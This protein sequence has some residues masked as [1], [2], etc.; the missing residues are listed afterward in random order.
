MPYDANQPIRIHD[1]P[2]P[3]SW[4]RR[5]RWFPHMDAGD[6]L[7]LS[8]I[9]FTIFA[10]Y[11]LFIVGS[12]IFSGGVCRVGG[13]PE[14]VSIMQTSD[15]YALIDDRPDHSMEDEGGSVGRFV[16]WE[17]P[18]R[19][20]VFGPA[21]VIERRLPCAFLFVHEGYHITEAQAVKLAQSAPHVIAGYD[22]GT[23]V[24]IKESAAD[25]ITFDLAP[26]TTTIKWFGVLINLGMW[27][28]L[29]GGIWVYSWFSFSLSNY[30][31]P[32]RSRA[33]KLAAHHCPRCSYDIR[34]IGSPRC[35][36]CGEALVVDPSAP[37]GT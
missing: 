26:A 22:F 3:P 11:A 2:P 19:R 13:R 16:W 8:S 32:R 17:L 29:A 5:S 25:E 31:D 12:T 15:G 23:P 7:T 30:Y 27:I 34:L 21:D 1:K 9:A 6:A 20:G 37:L 24:G 28:S 35:P 18:V 4:Q 10:G 33:I 14:W 36:E